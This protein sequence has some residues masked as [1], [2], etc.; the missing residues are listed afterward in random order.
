MAGDMVQTTR[1]PTHSQTTTKSPRRQ[2]FHCGLGKSWPD[3]GYSLG[4][5]KRPPQIGSVTVVDQK[6]TK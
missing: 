2:S 5:S 4:R 6:K 3:T 1:E